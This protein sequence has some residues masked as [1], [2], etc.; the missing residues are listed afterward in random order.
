MNRELS[1][2]DFPEADPVLEI[3]RTFQEDKDYLFQE[4]QKGEIRKT[5]LLEIDVLSEEIE[6]NCKKFLPAKTITAQTQ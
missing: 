4:A 1:E 3:D 6:E 5:R 2:G